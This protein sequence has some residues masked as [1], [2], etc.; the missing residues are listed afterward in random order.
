MKKKMALLSMT[1]LLASGTANAGYSSSYLAAWDN[2]GQ[3]GNQ[4][5][6]ATITPGSAHIAADNMVRSSGAGE[7]ISDSF[8]SKGFNNPNNFVQFGFSVASGYTAHLGELWI[9]TKSSATGPKSIGVF[10]SADNYTTAIA[11]IIEDGANPLYSKISLDGLGPVTGTFNI[12]LK[13]TDITAENGTFSVINYVASDNN[14]PLAIPTPIPAAAGLFGSGLFGLFG[15][16]R[17]QNIDQ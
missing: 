10:T 9:G 8:S 14:Y 7:N 17:K 4:D 1:L 16:R 5:Y 11:T 6:T 15:Y 12:R 13:P 2:N 3:T